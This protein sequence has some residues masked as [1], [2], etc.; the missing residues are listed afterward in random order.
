MWFAVL[1]LFLSSPWLVRGVMTANSTSDYAMEFWLKSI[2]QP[3]LG[4]VTLGDLAVRV[5]LN[6]RTYLTAGL[7]G[8][9]IPSQVQLTYVNTP[10][11]LR[12]GAPWAGADVIIAIILIAGLVRHLWQQRGL[13]EWYVV[14]YVGIALLWPWEPTRL[15]VPLI[16]LLWMYFLAEIRHILNGEAN[17]SSSTGSNA[18]RRATADLE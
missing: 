18:I 15:T 2:E 5:L 17:S 1:A 12:L 6:T 14:I 10:E 8:A 16:P 13:A 3:E 4:T 11:A 7:P 9:I